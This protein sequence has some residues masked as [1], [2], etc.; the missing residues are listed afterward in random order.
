MLIL[1]HPLAFLSLFSI[2]L[3]TLADTTQILQYKIIKKIPHDRNSFTQGLS[4]HQGV[5]FESTGGYGQS[6][7]QRISLSNGQLLDTHKLPARYFAEGL[8]IFQDNIYQLSW[9]QHSGF[10]YDLSFKQTG[11][12]SYYGEGWGLTHNTQQLIMSNGS[13]K[14]SFRE[15]GSFK[16]HHTITVRDNNKKVSQLNELEWI[17]G[18]IYANIWFSNWLVII[19]P[20][21][22]QVKAKVDLADLLPQSE[23]QADTDVLN[24]IAYDQE[25]GEL[26]VTGKR[27]PWLYQIELENE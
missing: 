7:L 26:W 19:D 11:R 10:I 18:E 1:L 15:P 3:P 17:K 22:G 14:L 8:T 4:I 20:Q 6:T 24:G 21:N 5:L 16:E 23:R 12:F 9:L 27:W 13:S 2:T 25:K